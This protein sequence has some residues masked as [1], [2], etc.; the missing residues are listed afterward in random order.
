MAKIYGFNRI[1]TPILERAELYERSIG[2]NT[3]IVSKE[4]YSFI[5]KNGDK[6]AL[7]PEATPSLVRAYIEHGMFNMPQPVKMFWLGPV[8]RH[9]KPQ[10]G[11]Y[12]QSHQFDLEIFGEENPV[13]DFL[14]KIGRAHV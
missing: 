7:R 12:R 13:A 6:I 11:R 14:I 2:K 8:F 1:D 10:A 4:M 5:D 9:E 3:D